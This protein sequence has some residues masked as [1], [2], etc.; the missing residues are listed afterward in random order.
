MK[1]AGRGEDRRGVVGRQGSVD[2]PDS[3]GAE[4]G[5]DAQAVH[6]GGEEGA[7]RGGDGLGLAGEQVEG[8]AGQAD[9]QGAT[10]LVE[11]G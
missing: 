7:W 10:G 11:D 5:V 3:G 8:V 2:E 4:G 9:V 1:Q 6:A